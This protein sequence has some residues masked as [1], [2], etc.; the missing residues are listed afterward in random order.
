MVMVSHDANY[1]HNNDDDD[2]D[3]D[4][5]DDDDDDD[6]PDQEERRWKRCPG[7]CWARLGR[8]KN[9]SDCRSCG[10][11]YCLEILKCLCYVS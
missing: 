4:Y 3:G 5:D 2:D 7:C 8:R 6:P 9:T 1:K 11:D 10:G